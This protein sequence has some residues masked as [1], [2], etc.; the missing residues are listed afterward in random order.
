MPCPSDRVEEVPDAQVTDLLFVHPFTAAALY[1][2]QDRGQLVAAVIRTAQR[3]HSLRA[4]GS[5]WSFSAA[6][7]ADAIVDTSALQRFLGP[8]FPAGA[9]ALAPDRIRGSGSDFL[10]RACANAPQAAGRHFVH[11]EAG[12]KIRDLLA[13]LAS[14]GLALPTM[15]DGAGQSLM[16]ALS[17]ATHGGDFEVPPLVEWI[18]ALHL[19]GPT[20]QEYWITPAPLPFGAPALLGTLPDWCPDTAVIADQDVFDAVRV[21]VGRMGVVYA[22][23]LEVVPQY[24]LVEVNLEH[25]WS[26]IRARLAIGTPAGGS[27]GGIF[28]QPLS[29]LDAGWFRSEVLQRTMYRDPAAGFTYVPGPP[30]TTS[31]PE[32]FDRF[33]DVYDELLAKLGLAGLASGLRGGPAMPLHHID[34]AISL[35]TPDRCWMRRRWKRADVLASVALAPAPEDAMRAAVKANKTN[36]PGIVDA[37][38]ARMEIDD[39]FINFGG[40]LTADPRWVTLQWY[41]DV[42]LRR[43][44]AQYAERGLT[45]GEAIFFMLYIMATDPIL[46]AGQDIAQA[47]S[48]LIGGAFSRLARA[49]PASGN[50]GENILDEHDYGLDGSQS[51]DSAEFHFDASAGRYLEFIDAVTALANQHFPVFGYIGIRFT[52]GATALIAMQQFALTASVEVST[53]RTRA[54]D[55]YAGFWADVHAAGNRLGGLAHW[56]Q[57]VRQSADE[58]AAR[59]GDRLLRWRSVL[60]DLS[61][62]GPGVF[63]TAFSRD[64]GLEPYNAGPATEDDAIDQFM[65]G[66]E[67]GSA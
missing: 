35:S 65:L 18:R 60:A 23:V 8:P 48:G 37:L 54:D 39:P 55:I 61:V 9:S 42:E 51:G 63:S 38:K 67:A 53:P 49:G 2:P 10:A 58:I 43:I 36:P 20:G 41:L 22:V 24:T 57:S 12:I 32:Y 11:V 14:C 5:N 28:D 19:V 52:P 66:L 31:V 16:G 1:K 17:T 6:G 7:V 33:P 56:G 25:R 4:I 34:L 47:A 59:Y 30:I 64:K 15:G 29:D 27:P 46:K 21:G 44:A 3:G 13:G 62:G 50:P 45:S 26:D 40:W